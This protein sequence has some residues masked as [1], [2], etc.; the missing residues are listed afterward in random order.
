M[1]ASAATDAER[2]RQFL[3]HLFGPAPLPDVSF[4]LWDGTSWPDAAP[5]AT[6]LVLRRPGSLHAMF[7]PGTEAGLA[8]A[9][10]AGDFDLEGNVEKACALTELL[11]RRPP[12]W[13]ARIADYRHIRRLPADPIERAAGRRFAAVG[14][15]HSPARNR[16][17]ISFHYDLSN[18][19]YA[20]WLDRRMIYSC[21]YFES[22]G[23]DLEAAQEAK[24]RHTC[25]KL[26]LQP[27]QR[28]LDLGCGWGGLAV[29]AAGAH[30]VDVRGITLSTR[31]AEW[32]VERS[33]AAGLQNSVHIELRDYQEL[34]EKEGYDA[35]VSVGM[36]E[37][38]GAEQLARYFRTA[39]ALLKPG[40]VMLNHA[41][42]EGVRPRTRRG[43]SFIARH[44]FPD[45]AI[46]PISVVLQAAESAGLEVRDVENLREHYMLTLRHWL[47][48]L[49]ARRAAALA[50]VDECTYRIWRLYLAGSAHG[51]DYGHLAIYQ[52]LLLKPDREGKSRLPLTRGHW[53]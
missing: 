35:I 32:A 45:T 34:D 13:K 4:R 30:G 26:R 53:H 15:L 50:Q 24:L 20:L 16:A 2:A 41:I 10:V 23:I 11:E 8:E 6:T 1:I 3:S 31:Q 27:G 14:T 36:S 49:E 51:F 5:R 18:E 17:A 44:V 38:V 12:G 7:A 43:P 21:A 33:T 47:Q 9:Y 40:G 39:A 48:R 28:L 19:Y 29:H 46:P 37:H 42:G 52:T 22:P 25:R